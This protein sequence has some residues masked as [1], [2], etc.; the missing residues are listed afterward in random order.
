MAQWGG[1]S[2]RRQLHRV[3]TMLHNHSAAHSAARPSVHSPGVL[4]CGL[5]QNYLRM[6]NAYQ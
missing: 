2:T 6:Y 3:R 5:S 1:L 4:I